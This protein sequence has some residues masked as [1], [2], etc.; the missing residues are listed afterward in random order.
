MRVP[1]L[2]AL[3]NTSLVAFLALSGCKR[4]GGGGTVDTEFGLDTRPRNDTCLAP[5][6]PSTG[7]AVALAP[8]FDSLTFTVPIGLYQ[9]PGSDRWYVM[10]QDGVVRTFPN[11]PNVTAAT[12]FIDASGPVTYAANSEYG[13]LGM[14]FHPSFATNGLF[15]LS[16][17][18]PGTGGNG[19][20]NSVLTSR[21]SKFSSAD[22]G[23]SASI[24]TE[25]ILFSLA[26]PYLNH[27][28]GNI[29]FGPDGF[30]YAGFGDGGSAN[31]PCESGQ[32]T[33]QLLG[34]MLRIDVDQG[35]T[36]GIPPTNPFAGGG[37]R[38]EI[39][40]WGLRNP[41]R[42][43]FDQATGDL[44][45]G[46]VGQ[47][48][49]EEIDRVELG[50]NY[51]WDDK[52]GARCFED[53]A[54]CDGGGRIDPIVEYDHSLGASVTGGFVYRGAA[55]PELVG[56]FIY[57]DFETG[58]IW[59]VVTD[60]G[61]GAPGAQVLVESGI[62]IGSFGQGADGEVYVLDYYGG[63][64]KKLVPTGTPQPDTFPQTLSAT[65]CANPNDATQPASGLIP[66]DVN[67]PLWSDGATKKRWMAL[68]NGERITIGTDGDWDL[69]TGSVLVKEFSAGGRRL[70]TRLLVRHDD[71]N[72]AGYTY[73]WND[74]QSD[75]TLLPAGK[76]I[77]VGAIEW[78][79]PSRGECLA[80]HTNAA[81]RSLGLE[82]AQLN[83]NVVYPGGRNAPQ[84]ATLRHINLLANALPAIPPKLPDPDGSLPVDMRARSYLHS[85]CANC[86]RP[87]GSGQGDLDL[88][89]ET[90]EV[91][92][93][94]C[95]VDPQEGD[96]G[97]AGAKLLVPGD[98]SKSLMSLRMHALDS[99]RMPDV[100]T[101]VVDPLGTTVVDEWINSIAAC[102]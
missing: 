61:T 93:N 20:G 99:N 13:L 34:K 17:T 28:G 10:Q 82:T 41:W 12:T 33:D 66:Y 78:T 2:S 22:G 70:E 64:I 74:A 46:D 95:N 71:G 36:Y 100:G 97:V 30:L 27:N 101:K 62:N 54:P 86:H 18:G 19:C 75:A 94:I 98:P 37:G 3:L 1:S 69:P 42:F 67:A 49:I 44:W 11:N 8:A 24:G 29:A 32:D 79:F 73:E 5:A 14:A 58:T 96:L 4:G 39:Y 53:A 43:S 26:Q 56:S 60:P 40:A 89:Y 31:D 85:N 55:I 92:M 65:G 68:P 25:A 90:P 9:A 59:A 23:L 83:R 63:K 91:S 88:L 80:C 87:G 102:P 15:Y 48:T 57:A 84:L 21:I 77:V 72:W 52:E 35:P 50:G 6:R 51:G 76:T 16:Y 45:V 47:D 7:V 81:G 38:A